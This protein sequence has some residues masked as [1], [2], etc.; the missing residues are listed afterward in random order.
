MKSPL[1]MFFANLP[2]VVCFGAAGYLLAI[3]R[4][5]GWGWLLFV[6]LLCCGGTYASNSDAR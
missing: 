3:G 4:E 5:V 6:G 2:S 1:M